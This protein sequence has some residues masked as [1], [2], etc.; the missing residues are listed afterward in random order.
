MNEAEQCKTSLKSIKKRITEAAK[1]M[2]KKGDYAFSKYR[3]GEVDVTYKGKVI[4]TGDFDS[5]ADAWFMD[6]KGVKGQKSFNS[7]GDAIKFFMKSKLTEV[8]EDAPVNATGDDVDMTPGK[9]IPKPLK[10]FKEHLEEALGGSAVNPEFTAQ[11]AGEWDKRKGANAHSDI[12][13]DDLGISKRDIASKP[14]SAYYWENAKRIAAVPTSDFHYKAYSIDKKHIE[15]KDKSSSLPSKGPNEFVTV[16]ISAKVQVLCAIIKT[17]ESDSSFSP[18]VMVFIP[19]QKRSLP[20]K[21][22]PNTTSQEIVKAIAKKHGAAL[23]AAY[24]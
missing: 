15:Y 24:R 23:T 21:F 1:V 20:M 5:G 9:R 18:S 16:I 7:P 10:R 3:N 13:T 12:M 8:D 2:A 14:Y 4:A 22:K 11:R 6:I 17:N 19:G